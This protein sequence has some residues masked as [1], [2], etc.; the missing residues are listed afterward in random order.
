MEASYLP[1]SLRVIMRP[2]TDASL[3]LQ[4]RS[5]GQSFRLRVA[6]GWIDAERGE[7]P[8][9]DLTL[10]G[11]PRGVIAVLIGAAP[12]QAEV[13]FEGDPEA[14][15]ALRTMVALPPR[16]LAEARDLIALPLAA[17]AVQP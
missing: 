1:N 12:E 13:A 16:L 3:S 5:S 8:D 14:L 11:S 10:E 2:P 6:N 15:D 17:P 9:P 4:L 7:A